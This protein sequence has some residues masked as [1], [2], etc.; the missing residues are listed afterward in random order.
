MIFYNL[1]GIP[2]KT[3]PEKDF[4]IQM[5]SEQ[6]FLRSDDISYNIEEVCVRIHDL[7]PEKLFGGL[8]KYHAILPSVTPLFYQSGLDSESSLSKLDFEKI[9]SAHSSDEVFNKLL[10]LFDVRNL[11]SSIQNSTIEVKYLFGLFYKYLNE[12]S[13]LLVNKPINETGIQY[14]AGF[15]VSNIYATLNSIIINLSSQLDFV[16]KLAFEIENLQNSFS[17]YPKMKSKDVLYGDKKKLTI[18]EMT[19]SL[20]ESSEYLNLIVT[21]RN[22]IIHNSSYDNLP[23]VYQTFEEGI[24]KEKFILLPDMENGRLITFKNRRRFFGSEIKFN[25]LLPDLLTEFWN[26]LHFTLNVIKNTANTV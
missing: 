22:E 25:E 20:F 2:T 5:D 1:N 24:L 18:N 7:I 17:T 14:A 10:Y 23:K 6:V 26:R 16:T 21:L 19:D 11:V 13:F 3:P 15:I 8:D 9:V 12:N 4:W